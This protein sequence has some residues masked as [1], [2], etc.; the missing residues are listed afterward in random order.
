MT[1]YSVQC[2]YILSQIE[3]L[4]PLQSSRSIHKSSEDHDGYYL[5]ATHTYHDL[6]PRYWK[7]YQYAAHFVSLVRS[8]TPKVTIYS[9]QAK[10]MMM[11]NGPSPDFEACFYNGKSMVRL[12]GVA[13]DDS[14]YRC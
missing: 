14:F 11:E 3:I 12:V 1:S 2:Y 10:C 4:K 13:C 7:K 8:K 9:D 6:P 5:H